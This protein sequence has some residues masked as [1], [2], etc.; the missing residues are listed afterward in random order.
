MGHPATAAEVTL[1][2][3]ENALAMARNFRTKYRLA[4]AGWPEGAPRGTRSLQWHCRHGQSRERDR[5]RT[6]KTRRLAERLT[7]DKDEQGRGAKGRKVPAWHAPARTGHRTIRKNKTR[8]TIVDNPCEDPPMSQSSALLGGYEG[9]TCWR[10]RKISQHGRINLS[11]LVGDCLAGPCSVPRCGFF[12][13]PP[14]A[15]PRHNSIHQSESA[16]VKSPQWLQL[17][18]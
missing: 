7:C 1:S 6:Q 12:H 14:P 3:L 4:S 11:A 9:P 16:E 8:P 18:P 2:A 5:P 15:R 13:G 17:H 10:P